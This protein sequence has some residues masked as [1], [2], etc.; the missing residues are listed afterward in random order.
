MTQRTWLITGVNSGFGR[1]LSEPEALQTEPFDAGHQDSLI[2][3]ASTDVS[4]KL[5]RFLEL[6]DPP[7]PAC[8]SR[9]HLP[10]RVL[11][12]RFAAQVPAYGVR[13]GESSSKVWRCSLGD[14]GGLGDVLAVLLVPVI[15]H[16]GRYLPVTALS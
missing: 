4:G 6:Q 14:H 12:I 15:E 2:G 7:V 1:A 16:K 3:R 13:L 10:A 9:V 5:I 8:H 11:R